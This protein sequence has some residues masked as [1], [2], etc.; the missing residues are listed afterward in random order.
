MPLPFNQAVIDQALSRAGGRCECQR[1]TCKHTGR[2]K[3]MINKDK[4]GSE[5]YGGWEARHVKSSG[6]STLA[7]CELLCAACFKAAGTAAK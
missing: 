2:C 3:N 4:R 7:N 6:A 5:G 1:S